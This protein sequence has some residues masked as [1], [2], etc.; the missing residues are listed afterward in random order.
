MFQ[1]L[2]FQLALFGCGCLGYAKTQ[3]PATP[4]LTAQSGP[5]F[6]A[7]QESNLPETPKP[8]DPASPASKTDKELYFSFSGSKWIDVIQWLAESSGLALH[9]TD[10][11][12]GSFSYSDN[13]SFTPQEAID[14]INLFLLPEDYTLVR[15][16]RLLSVINLTDPKSIKQLDTLA[17]LVSIDELDRLESHDMVKCIF[18]L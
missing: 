14:R 11:P 2:C 12:P 13:R 17:R 3:P 8:Q 16:G 9:V 15:S 7:P 10:L 5:V 6:K 4:P 18:P 1:I